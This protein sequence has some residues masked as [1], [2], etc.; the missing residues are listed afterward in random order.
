MS[1]NYAS[2][3]SVKKYTNKAKYS[4]EIRRE[5]PSQMA[6]F[7]LDAHKS[8]FRYARLAL[9]QLSC[10]MADDGEY[11]EKSAQGEP[12]STWIMRGEQTL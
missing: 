4:N 3:F 12:D 11:S 10:Q 6:C 9:E 7:L 2:C 1:M 8:Q 5:N